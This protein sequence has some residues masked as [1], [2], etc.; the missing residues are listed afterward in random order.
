MARSPFVKTTQKRLDLRGAWEGHWVEVKEHIGVADQK[1]IEGSA[2]T[3][4]KAATPKPGETADEVEAQMDL[5]RMYMTQLKVYLLGW[6]FTTAEGKPVE[7]TPSAI[8]MLEPDCADE[9]TDRLKEWLEHREADK[10][11]NP[12]GT[13][14]SEQRSA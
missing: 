1:R 8:D 11:A 10:A 2:F 12:T 7:V 6:S 14:S 13:T 5:G 4:L 3:S 9:I